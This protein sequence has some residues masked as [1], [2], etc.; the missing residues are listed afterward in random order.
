MESRLKYF[1]YKKKYLALKNVMYGGNTYSSMI[2]KLYTQ[3]DSVTVG[4]PDKEILKNSIQ[5]HTEIE[6]IGSNDQPLDSEFEFNLN[7]RIVE[8]YNIVIENEEDNPDLRKNANLTA[9]IT[10]Y[11]DQYNDVVQLANKVEG[12]HIE[13]DDQNRHPTPHIESKQYDDSQSPPIQ[14]E[15][16][17]IPFD[18][19]KVTNHDQC[20]G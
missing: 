9:N 11:F 15:D 16:L 18:I 19:D 14:P 13:G 2:D 5:E 4:L 12:M 20:E 1:K 7:S 6:N 10:Y 3:L 8:L 17:D